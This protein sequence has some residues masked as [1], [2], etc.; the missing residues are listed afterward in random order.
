MPSTTKSG[1]KC[2]LLPRPVRTASYWHQSPSETYKPDPDY[3]NDCLC[4]DTE[5]TGLNYLHPFPGFTTP[6]R[7]FALATTDVKDGSQHYWDWKVDP[8]TRSVTYTKSSIAEIRKVILQYKYWVFHNAGHDVRGMLHAGII[9]P[10]EL[11]ARWPYIHDTLPAFHVLDSLSSHGLKDLSIRLLGYSDDDETI[12]KERV[13]AHHRSIKSQL[14]AFEKGKE[15]SSRPIPLAPEY[16]A[17]Y[18]LPKHLDPK[19][20][21]CKTYCLNDTERGALLWRLAVKQLFSKDGYDSQGK[22]AFAH[23]AREQALLR[24][25]YEMESMGIH[26][27]PGAFPRL[28]NQYEGMQQ[29]QSA[30]MQKIA[31][32]YRNGEELK[33]K[34]YPQMQDLLFTKFKLPP[35]RLGATGPSTDKDTIEDLGYWLA[36]QLSNK[37]LKPDERKRLTDA[38]NFL[39]A[40]T[41]FRSNDTAYTYLVG[42]DERKVQ[43]EVIEPDTRK[44]YLR[45]YLYPSFNQ[46]ATRTTRYSSSDPNIQNV[47]GR[48]I[49][50]G[51]DNEHA[52]RIRDSFGPPPGFVW[53]SI[54]WNQ[55]ELRLMAYA[56]GD[57]ALNKSLSEGLDRHQLTADTINQFR[58]Q[59]NLP[60]LSRK[61]AKNINFAWQYGAGDAKLSLMAGIPA[62]AFSAAMAAAYP[63]IVAYMDECIAFAKRHR[64]IE[65]MT[66][67][68]LYVPYGEEYKATN[69]RI[70]GSAGDLAKNAMLQVN[71]YIR[72]AG[73]TGK[74]GLLMQIHDELLFQAWKSVP[75][76]SIGDIRDIIQSQGNLIGCPTPAEVSVSTASW[77]RPKKV[78]IALAA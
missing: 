61:I 20:T 76:S 72:S 73:L 10:E 23:Y 5:T 63:G 64:Y 31:K 36:N 9:T 25:T 17:D 53:W 7:A 39:S 16:Q 30:V 47:G 58:S 32:R 41:T 13:K 27:R 34:S 71:S 74:V 45:D 18:W 77:G 78:N 28:K 33:P 14:K 26:I 66:G 67:Y 46:N 56:S 49:D 24:D 48:D 21:S 54:D 75:R 2:N 42:Y 37:R 57:E 35:Q 44:K 50:S 59:L 62:D 3:I 43:R 19:D 68:R 6:A 4:I 29:E 40:L 11:E 60:P 55:L 15:G 51:E 8:H 22:P 12:L 1:R 52:S 65:T 70:Q 38:D 69:Y